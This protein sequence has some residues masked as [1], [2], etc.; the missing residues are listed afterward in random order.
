MF[1]RNKNNVNRWVSKHFNCEMIDQVL[2]SALKL[3]L[4]NSPFF[5]SASNLFKYL[6]DPFSLSEPEYLEIGKFY[7]V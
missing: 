3:V 4:R 1:L 2:L 7:V 6:T 5:L